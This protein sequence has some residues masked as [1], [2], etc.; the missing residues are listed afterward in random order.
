MAAVAAAVVVC[1]ALA[2]VAHGDRHTADLAAVRASIVRQLVPG[3]DSNLSGVDRDVAW[4]TATLGGGGQWSDVD[5]D[6][7]ADRSWWHTAEHARRALLMASA[8]SSPHSAHC[9]STAV[10]L[11]ADK[12]MEW[13]LT[14]DPQNTNWWWSKA[15]T[16]PCHPRPHPAAR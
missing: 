13:W 2:A 11:A 6:D 9:N 7:G 14:N 8:V 16:A 5:Y 3:A 4:C 10:R 1:M 15:S 12:A